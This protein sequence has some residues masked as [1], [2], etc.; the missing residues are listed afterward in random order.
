[1]KRTT[2]PGETSLQTNQAAR[3][4]AFASELVN[5]M[6]LAGMLGY[7]YQGSRDIYQ[8]LGYDGFDQLNFDKFY[9]MY[10]RD[11]MAKAI[12]KRPV[13]ATWRGAVELSEPNTKE[14]TKLEKAWGELMKK[15]SLKLK[16][17]LS[18]LDRLTGIGKYA[19]LVLG[20]NDVKIITDMINPVVGSNLKLMFLKPLSE[21][22]AKIKKY[23][24]DTQNE[25]YG[26][27]LI[28]EITLITPNGSSQTVDVHWSRVIHV[29]DDPL[30]DEVEGTP[31]LEDV[32][33]R[34]KDM[35]KIVGGSA[36]MFW[37]GARPGY[38]AAVE[39]GY[40]MTTKDEADLQTQIDEFENN[41]RR[42]LK[43]QGIKLSGLEM[44]VANPKDHVDIQIQQ[45]SAAKAIPKR[46][47]M[48]SERG[49]LSSGQDADEWDAF[50]KG[51]REEFVEPEIVRP[52]V[53]R[54]IQFGILPPPV[55]EEKGY[56]VKWEDMF[57]QSEEDKAKVGQIRSDS[58]AKYANSGGESIMP[59]EAF[60]EYFLGLTTEQ[61]ELITKMCQS[62]LN[63][64]RQAIAEQQ[65]AIDEEQARIEKNRRDMNNPPT[66]R[67]TSNPNTPA[68]V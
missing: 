60:L 43:T 4:A 32:W 55:D 6:T 62:S 27:P 12:I 28:Y 29:V 23:E 2:K 18:R 11:S 48:G 63:Q 10:R 38:N 40:T 58:L 64:E 35:E 20:L 46:I 59:L 51:R 36:E 25:R 50:T 39:P 30:Q 5:R 54:C 53:D 1:M 14:D 37:R 49:E 22:Y 21:K 16:N 65:A 19:V 34:L 3:F 57:A 8:A 56:E 61:I 45:F 68:N 31:R 44:Q 7:S 52:F 15:N 42:I 41:M 9:V 67:R 24:T 47:L 26:L 17:K 33:N 13:D 66:G